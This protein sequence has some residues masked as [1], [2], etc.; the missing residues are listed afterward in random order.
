VHYETLDVTS[1]MILVVTHIPNLA[2]ATAIATTFQIALQV[3]I[4]HHGTMPNNPNLV[5]T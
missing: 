5:P 1:N 3:T 2:Y 4:A